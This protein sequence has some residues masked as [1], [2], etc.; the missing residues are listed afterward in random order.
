MRNIKR[1]LKQDIDKSAKH[2]LD[3][4][5]KKCGISKEPTGKVLALNNGEQRAI[6]RG[7]IATMVVILLCAVLIGG[8][9]LLNKDN[10]DGALSKHQFVIVD[11]NPSLEI[12]YDENGTVV[13]AKAYNEDAEIVLCDLDLTSIPYSSALSKIFD[14]CVE[15]GYLCAEREDNAIMVSVVNEDGSKNEDMTSTI[16]EKLVNEFSSKKILGVVITGIVNSELQPEADKYGIDVQ[17]YAYIKEYIDMGGVL[18]EGEYQSIS[19]REIRSRIYEKENEQKNELIN[20]ANKQ[21]NEIRQGLEIA[22]PQMVQGI[23]SSVNTR[24][25]ILKL[26]QVENAEI[27]S[28]YETLVERLNEPQGEDFSLYAKSFVN[29]LQEII[30]VE[31]NDEI[32]GLALEFIAEFEEINKIFDELFELNKTHKEIAQD[33]KDHFEQAPSGSA[34]DVDKWQSEKEN[35]FSSNWFEHKDKWQQEQDIPPK[36]NSQPSEPNSEQ[37]PSFP[38]G[39]LPK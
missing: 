25:A 10:G 4:I 13:S 14:R 28:K 3:A 33:R 15:L 31:A 6:T 24:I 20:N 8:F 32:K 9:M 12:E 27:I 36:S 19:I 5:K 2:D 37:K 38:Q 35:D 26:N 21:A 22:I 1:Q 18:N 30:L 39:W 16:K 29:T 11:I 17:K 34:T 7:F 23:T